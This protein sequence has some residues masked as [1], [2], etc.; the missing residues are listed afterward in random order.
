[1]IKKCYTCEMIDQNFDV[2]GSRI[3]WVWRWKNAKVAFD[4]LISS[5]PTGVSIINFRRVK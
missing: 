1:M 4:I 5:V 3:V 2:F